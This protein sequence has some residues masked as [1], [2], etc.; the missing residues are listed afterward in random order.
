MT[1]TIVRTASDER[2]PLP[3]RLSL[4]PAGHV[5][6]RLDGAWWPR[7]RDL[8]RELPALTATLDGLW[9]RITRVTVN[10]AQW[11]V[12]PRKVPVAGHTVHVGWFTDEQDPHALI[13]RSY[14]VGRWD[15]L[16]VPPETGA[17]VAA[18]LMAAAAGVGDLGTASGLVAG[19]AACDVRDAAGGEVAWETDG[20]AAT[21]P[22]P[23]PLPDQP[24][25]A[26]APGG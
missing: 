3:A 4:T 26:A 2:V 5:A 21:A 12:I 22:P 25:T 1:E 13:L 17:A 11:P 6:G 19:E 20:G 18:R 16:V 14:S 9:G 7:S 24:V 15:L 10:P 23:S 8:A